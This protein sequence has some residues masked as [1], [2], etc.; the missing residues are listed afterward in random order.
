MTGLEMAIDEIVESVWNSSLGLAVVADDPFRLDGERG[1][2]FGG[3][4]Q[5]TGAWDGVV[6]VQCSEP[7]AR[8]ATT[9]MMGIPENEMALADVQ[10]T[11]GEL[12]N[13]VGGNV[14]SLL[15]GKC[16]LGLP[17][18]VEGMDF[19]MRLPGSTQLLQCAF[20]AEGEP[21]SVTVLRHTPAERL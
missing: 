8:L 21:F 11:V 20:R 6:A 1:R 3:V 2:I 9:A 16:A 12:A 13:M 7:L 15:E 14:K 19:R 10:D 18:V 17:V 4:V 5:I